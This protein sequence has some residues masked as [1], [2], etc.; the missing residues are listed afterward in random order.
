MSKLSNKK[1]E[2]I[3][4]EVLRV[5][6]ENSPKAL[7]T[8]YIANEVIRD[9]EFVLSLM[10]EMERLGVV[11]GVK[12]RGNKSVKKKIR[13]RWRLTNRAFEEYKK[14]ISG[15]SSISSISDIPGIP[16]RENGING[17]TSGGIDG[18]VG[19]VVGGGV[20]GKG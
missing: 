18:G 20:G 7:F 11:E 14:L 12:S 19:E 4:E 1:R 10:K 16:H 9:N 15:I 8:S 5:L 17:G 2:R 3:K 13:T 6:Y